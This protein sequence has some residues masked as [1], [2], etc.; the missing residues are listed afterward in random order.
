MRQ[1]DTDL[2]VAESPLR[3]LG[4]EL[5]AR[6]TVVRLP[7]RK[8]FVHSPIHATPELLQRVRALGSVTHVVAPNRFH[9]IFAG[10][11]QQAFPEVALYVAPG[12]DQKR[13]DLSIVGVL[14]DAPETAWADTIDQVLLGGIPSTNEIVFFHRPSAT[15]IASDLAFNVGP[16]SPRLTRTVFRMLGAY[17]RLA[18]SA[19]ERL[20]VRDRA[21]FRGSLE[22]ILA[23]P[24]ER[25]VIAH[26]EVLE[27]GGKVALQRGYAWLG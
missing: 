27:R 2:W 21:A 5:G 11:W 12:L 6:M 14:G 17:G 13:R 7:G 16:S 18:P 10:E 15:L 3:M 19:L 1:L 20:L 24:F 9:H 25:V 4:L 26:G 23:W 8:L 22:R